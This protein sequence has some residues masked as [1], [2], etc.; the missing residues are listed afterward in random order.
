MNRRAQVK[1]VARLFAQALR[2]TISAAQLNRNSKQSPRKARRK[3][4]FRA[5]T[6]GLPSYSSAFFTISCASETISF[7]CRLRSAG[8]PHRA[9]RYLPC[10]KDAP[11]TIRSPT[12]LSDHRWAA[13]VAGALVSLA[14]IGSPARVA[15]VTGRG[16]SFLSAVFCS[17]IAGASIR[18]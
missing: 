16:E 17:E 18:V 4:V 9:C 15:A 1:E 14:V 2:G 13:S 12:P 7:R 10:R 8:S 5:P 3:G 11:Q 6:P